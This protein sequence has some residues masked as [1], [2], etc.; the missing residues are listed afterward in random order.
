M[1]TA[2]ASTTK[3][4]SQR[5]SRNN[6]LFSRLTSSLTAELR[7]YSYTIADPVV[8]LKITTVVLTLTKTRIDICLGANMTAKTLGKLPF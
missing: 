4:L 3:K 8:W 5:S 1:T 6:S 2:V 7:N